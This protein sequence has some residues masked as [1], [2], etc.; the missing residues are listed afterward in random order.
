MNFNSFLGYVATYVFAGY[1]FY[2]YNT[3][4]IKKQNIDK[5]RKIKCHCFFSLDLSCRGNDCSKE[6]KRMCIRNI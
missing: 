1:R 6:Y 4:N 2:E 5:R 3:K